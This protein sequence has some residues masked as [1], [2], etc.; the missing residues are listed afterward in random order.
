MNSGQLRSGM[1]ALMFGG[2]LAAQVPSGVDLRWSGHAALLF[3]GGDLKDT[4]GTGPGLSLGVAISQDLPRGLT[5]RGRFEGIRFKTHKS[6][7]QDGTHSAYSHTLETGVQGWAL[8]AECLVHPWARVSP[9]SVGAGLHL[10]RWTLDVTNTL[11][12][13]VGMATVRIQEKSKPT[14]NKLGASLFMGYQ[15]NRNLGLEAR[16]LSSAY[17]WEG[18]RVQI[19]QL[20]LNWSF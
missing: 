7:E 17:G 2:V 4:A 18:E 14:W 11:D 15:I 8:G 19:G 6:T 10:V 13:T 1:I 3:S 9:V 12:M 20:G 16:V 5:L